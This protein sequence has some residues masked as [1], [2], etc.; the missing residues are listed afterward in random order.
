[1]LIAATHAHFEAL[2]AGEPIDS[3]S[4]AP[5][6]I[7]VRE[8]LEML[9]SLAQT[10]AASFQPSAWLIVEDTE[11]VGLCSLL[12]TPGDSGSMMIGYGVAASRR[13][14]GVAKRAIADVLKWARLDTRISII[15][16]ETSVNNMASQCVLESNGFTKCGERTCSEDGE[17]ICWQI[18][19]TV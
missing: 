11:I 18:N 7:E 9:Q 14:N 6:G 12:A 3:F 19:V 4:I 2:K 5:G 17:L 8:T 1:M 16:A 13:G 10:V 15:A